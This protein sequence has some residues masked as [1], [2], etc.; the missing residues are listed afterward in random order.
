MSVVVAA[1]FC[2]FVLG[3][4]NGAGSSEG[5]GYTWSNPFVFIPSDF[6]G[7]LRCFCT[8]RKWR[9]VCKVA[10]DDKLNEDFWSAMES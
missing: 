3:S 4:D 9:E 10:F 2:Y 5:K 8:W 7:C 1:A 6:D